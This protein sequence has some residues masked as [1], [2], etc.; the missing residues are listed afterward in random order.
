MKLGASL[1]LT[2]PGIPM[3]WMGQEFGES[4]P[5]TM[6]KQPL[7]WVLLDNPR[8]Q[9]L[10][11]H[12]KK[13]IRVRKSNPALYSDTFEPLLNDYGRGLIAFKRWNMHGNVVVVVAN[14]RD[15]YGGGFELSGGL[16]DGLWREQVW[17]YDA[18]VQNGVLRDTLAE[19][20]V[21]IFVKQ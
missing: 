19:S 11:Q 2:A 14:L 5:K 12:Y 7:D 13:L 21:K 3:I 10:F 18:V 1:L 8:N 16:E 4:S 15:D 9:D 6:D 17:N 20:E